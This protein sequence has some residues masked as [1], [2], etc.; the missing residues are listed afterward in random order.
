MKEEVRE[1]NSRAKT[2][3][4]ISFDAVLQQIQKR[5]LLRLTYHGEC[6]AHLER[7]KEEKEVYRD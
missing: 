5:L 2:R 4:I 7:E 3:F 1:R 6:A